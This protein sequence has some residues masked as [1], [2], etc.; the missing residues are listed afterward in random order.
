MKSAFYARSAKQDEGVWK[1]KT[2]DQ[3]IYAIEAGG[4]SIKIRA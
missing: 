1:I 4:N 2:D 3:K